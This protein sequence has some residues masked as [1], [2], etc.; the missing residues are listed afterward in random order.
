VQTVQLQCGSCSNMM[1][2]SVEHM[3]A[4]VQCP[5]CAAVVQTPPRSALGPPPG[6]DPQG[7][8][9]E[10]PV[11]RIQAPE[12]ESIFSEPEPSDDL[13]GAENGP[14]VQLPESPRRAVSEPEAEVEAVA[15][16][17]DEEEEEV[18]LTAMRGRLA[19]ERK[20]SSVAPIMLV[21]L[22]PYA[23]FTT[24]F[25][26]YL[27]YTWPKIETFEWLPDPKKNGQPK[28][29][30]LPTHD[31]PIPAKIKAPLKETIRIGQ[32]EFTPLK[33]SRTAGN[34]LIFEFKAKNV[35]PNLLIKPLEAGFFEESKGV[36]GTA[37]PFTFLELV[38]GKENTRVYGGVLHFLKGESRARFDGDLSPGQE[39]VVQ[40]ATDPGEL[41]RERV[42]ALLAQ[43]GRYQWRVQVRR[44]RA[45]VHGVDTSLTAVFGV[46][47]GAKDVA[48]EGA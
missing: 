41:T 33:I 11:P 23:I 35:S 29:V 13:F 31:L 40:L 42:R 6:P 20:A 14:K 21:F 2:I 37:R 48:N 7:A 28:V 27:L 25:L 30:V 34:D 17:E 22:V 45:P 44:G 15:A 4:Q 43:N 3:G 24:L 26:A 46:D 16:I 19:Q 10:P 8:A 5:H 12:R 38:G 36:A 39:C 9:V 47:F 1:A 18:D 32:M